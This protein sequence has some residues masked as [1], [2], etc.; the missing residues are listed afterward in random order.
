M[1]HP[2]P[3]SADQELTP[4]SAR[5]LL[6]RLRDLDLHAP[7][8]RVRGDLAVSVDGCTSLD[9]PVEH[10]VRYRLV[11]S[12]GDAHVLSIR[13][14]GPDLMLALDGEHMCVALRVDDAGRAAARELSARLAESDGARGVEHFL[15]RIVR[16]VF[17][18]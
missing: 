5:E 6:R 8:V 10:G 15:R 4:S 16:G 7:H 13:I 12:D 2:V 17:A 1:R 3:S 9:T 11:G 18:A 14:D